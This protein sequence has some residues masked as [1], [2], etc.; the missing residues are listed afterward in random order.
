MNKQH[1]ILALLFLTLMISAVVFFLLRMNKSDNYIPLKAFPEETIFYF[2]TND[3]K[4]MLS[5]IKGNEN[6]MSE[7][8]N[9]P[10]GT[11][12]SI[13]ITDFE[14][15]TDNSSDQVL[16]NLKPRFL[17]ILKIR[18]VQGTPMLEDKFDSLI[19]KFDPRVSISKKDNKVVWLVDEE[20]KFSFVILGDLILFSNDSKLIDSA[21]MKISKGSES[22]IAEGSNKNNQ[23]NGNPDFFVKFEE[24][25][26]IR[27]EDSLAFSFASKIC[28]YKL[29]GLISISLANFVSDDEKSRDLMLEALPSLINSMFEGV[30]WRMQRDSQNKIK[31]IVV[32]KTE[33]SLTEIFKTT[34]RVNEKKNSELAEFI[35][36][37][38]SSFTRY[39]FQN[40]KLAWR[41]IELS[42]AERTGSSRTITNLLF[43]NYG[44]K[45]AE[46]FLDSVGPEIL[47][48]RF[49][50]EDSVVISKIKDVEKLKRAVIPDLTKKPVREMN[51]EIWKTNRWE[52]A[53]YE[54]KVL[55]GNLG[56]VIKCLQ[57]K[58]SNRE[59]S[60]KSSVM[61]VSKSDNSIVKSETSFSDS[62]F[63]YQI[64]SESGLISSLANLILEIK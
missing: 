52:V 10:D 15:Q 20:E 31:D 16:I 62:G 58:G 55:L 2:E 63:E 49:D 56:S 32:L 11:S 46:D 28:L 3:L 39:N 42:I 61:T 4:R 30:S 29:V 34:L 1:K 8:K 44:I 12:L 24:I 27:T 35:P 51:A 53:F 60:S 13:A 19:R 22:V 26:K 57:A 64:F 36:S 17:G 47:V 43:E 59:I 37:E 48:V 6:L 18:Y 25:E 21:V 9:I 5:T 54:G 40:P 7:L 14:F 38:A 33:D 45:D 41:S 50:E 23:T